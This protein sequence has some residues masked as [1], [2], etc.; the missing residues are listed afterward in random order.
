MP[1]LTRTGT[2]VSGIP[3]LSANR[4]MP[5]FSAKLAFSSAN[6]RLVPQATIFLA[7]SWLVVS[8]VLWAGQAGGAAGG[9]ERAQGVGVGGG[10]RGAV[11]VEARDEALERHEQRVAVCEE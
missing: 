10:D 7:A 11:T 6:L 8:D 9:E 3:H 4:Q 1:G 2:D 5:K